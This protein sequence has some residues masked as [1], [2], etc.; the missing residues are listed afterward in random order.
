ME[1][2]RFEV[3]VALQRFQEHRNR[4]LRVPLFLE[5]HT[6]AVVDVLVVRCTGDGLVEIIERVFVVLQC[7]F[8]VASVEVDRSIVRILVAC[9]LEVPKRCAVVFQLECCEAEVVEI[10]RVRVV[11]FR[12][13]GEGL[14]RELVITIVEVRQAQHVQA[15]CRLFK[16]D[17]CLQ[18]FNRFS[19]PALLS[20]RVSAEHECFA[21]DGLGQVFRSMLVAFQR[22]GEIPDCPLLVAQVVVADTHFK[23]PSPVFG[24]HRMRLLEVG[25]GVI[26]L[27]ESTES[28]STGPVVLG[29]AFRVLGH[30]VLIHLNC[31]RV[32]EQR[33]L[34]FIQLC[35]AQ[36]SMVVVHRV[37]RCVLHRDGEF[38][39]R[40]S[41]FTHALFH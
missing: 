29:D 16:F 37:C 6:L 21:P 23:E 25:D 17:C 24:L 40:R 3:G 34:V 36:R 22:D 33:E 41:A 9:L 38:L 26:E 31:H 2:R 39:K 32:V 10:D 13:A 8:C 28:C 5:H 12:C 11:Q 19:D 4:R 30:A 7:K 20:T 18:I 27:P 35:E 14:H 15:R 1:Q